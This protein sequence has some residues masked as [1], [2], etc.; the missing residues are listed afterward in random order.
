M[1]FNYNA[2]CQVMN[3]ISI[4][5]ILT[6][7]KFIIKHPLHLF[8]SHIHHFVSLFYDS[9]SI[10]PTYLDSIFH[11]TSFQ[12]WKCSVGTFIHQRLFT[13]FQEKNSNNNT[14]NEVSRT[15]YIPL[16][17]MIFFF[18]FFFFSSL[19]QQP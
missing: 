3:N 17:C 10:Q 15:C 8:V 11:C 1:V 9:S 5:V 6:T 16:H 4:Y 2:Q 13:C 18:F 19:V 12:F 7:E 14:E